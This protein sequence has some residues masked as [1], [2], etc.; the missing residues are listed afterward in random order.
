MTV[1]DPFEQYWVLLNNER[2]PHVGAGLHLLWA[3]IGPKI[4]R[5]KHKASIVK[6]RHMPRSRWDAIPHL[7]NEGQNIC[8]IM[9]GLRAYGDLEPAHA[10]SCRIPTYSKRVRRK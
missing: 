2:L 1:S 3:A 7:L 10:P 4:V 9:E 6:A 5:W 8:T